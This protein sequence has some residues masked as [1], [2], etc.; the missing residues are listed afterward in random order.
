VHLCYLTPEFPHPDLRAS[1]GIGA[2]IQHLSSS[3]AARGHRVTVLCLADQSFETTV[4]GVCLKVVKSTRLPKV[5]WLL[6]RWRLQKILRKMVQHEWLDLVEAPDWCGL[7]AGITPGCPVVVRCNGTDAFFGQLLGYKPR[8]KVFLAE[9]KAILQ[10]DA[11]AAVSD[12][13]A[14]ITGQLFNRQITTIIPNGVD[15]TRF[16][17]CSTAISPPVLLYFG[18]LTRKKGVLE[19]PGIFRLVR[20]V[21]PD[22]RLVMVGKSTLDKQTGQDTVDVLESL[23]CAADKP[24]IHISSGLPYDQIPAIIA[25]ATV[26]VFPSFAECLPVSWIEAMLMQKPVVA[27]NIG[28]AHDMIQDGVTGFLASPTDHVLFAEKIVTLLQHPDL[29]KKMG[30]AARTFALTHFSSEVVALQTEAWYQQILAQR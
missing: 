21:L 5:G 20:Q 1:G 23:I 26:C 22:T 3:M 7:S 27:S 4:D 17:P 11:V 2:S 25:Q 10:A 13:T 28:W 18:T 14:R 8:W 6:N 24:I 29:A 30:Q 16:Q 15:A 19:L 9:K 12:F